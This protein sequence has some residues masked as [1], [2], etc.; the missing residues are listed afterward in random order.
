MN[1]NVPTQYQNGFSKYL[2]SKK[3]WITLIVIAVGVGAYVGI[4]QLINYYHLRANPPAPKTVSIESVVPVGNP[5]TRDTL[6]DGIPDWEKI[7]VGLNPSDPSSTAA[8]TKISQAAGADTMNQLA[9]TND[10]D[11]VA[12]TLFNN[13][14]NVSN[15]GGTVDDTTVTDQTNQ[16]LTN[17][18]SAITPAEIYTD[19]S[20]Q[21]VPDTSENQQAYK[22]SMQ[23][24]DP[25]DIF[26][27][28]FQADLA[29]YLSAGTPEKSVTD[30]MAR[31]QDLLGK[32]QTIPTPQGIVTYQVGNMNALDSFVKIVN[33]YDTTNQDPLYQYANMSLLQMYE[34][35]IISNSASILDYYKDPKAAV[36]EK[37]I[38]AQQQP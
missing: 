10:T 15:Q 8:F 13:I 4:P 2:P 36:F 17:Y 37:V 18:I 33:A 29:A 14:V 23:A 16:E 3:I 21:A 31:I 12:Y 6:Q 35:S 30:M 1:P 19:A 25:V 34:A 20:L 5:T 28:S 26:D 7:A 22:K 11:K 24:L 9:T 32:M 27:T 38:Q